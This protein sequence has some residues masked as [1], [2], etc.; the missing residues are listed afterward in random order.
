MDLVIFCLA[1]FG[2]SLL[3]KEMEGPFGIFSK[4]RNLMLRL[5]IIG[6]QFFLATQCYFCMGIWSAATLLLLRYACNKLI[7]DAV[8]WVLAGAVVCL[9]LDAILSRLHR[10]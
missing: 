9:F 8:C 1:T 10:E 2:L 5:P 6:P 7:V 4:W 3:V